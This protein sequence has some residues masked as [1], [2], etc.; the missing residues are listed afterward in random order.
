MQTNEPIN[1]IDAYRMVRR[2]SAEA[3][4]KTKLGCHV[5]RATGITAYLEAGGALEKPRPWRRT[6]ART[7]PSSTPI[8]YAIAMAVDG[9][10]GLALG[11]L[12]DR[13]GSWAMILA[14]VISAAAAPLV[15]LGGFTEAVLGMV[16]WGI[17]R[18]ARMRKECGPIT[19][20]QLHH[21]CLES[22]ARY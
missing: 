13:I 21:Q 22:F 15:F 19:D 20:P 16:C 2:R 17:F 14:T 5:F 4:F 3:G 18:Q 6:K 12:F 1:R 11:S 10:A 9:A 8:A 7:R